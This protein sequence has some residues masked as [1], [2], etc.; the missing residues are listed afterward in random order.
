MTVERCMEL[1]VFLDDIRPAISPT[2]LGL[3]FN[4]CPVSLARFWRMW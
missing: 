3:D 1:T 4:D 2:Y